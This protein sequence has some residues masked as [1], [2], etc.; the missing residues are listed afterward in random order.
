MIR[1]IFLVLVL[2][3]AHSAIAQN[4]SRTFTSFSKKDNIYEVKVNDGFYRLV[5][6]SS[7]IIETSFIPTGEEFNKESHA[8]IAKPENVNVKVTKAENEIELESENI[9]VKIQKKPFQISYFN[10]EKY[11][12]SEKKGYFKG[13]Y[14]EKHFESTNEYESIEFNLNDD[15]ILYGTGTR[16]LGMDRRGYKLQLYN[17]AHYG[18]TNESVLMNYCMPIVVSSELYMLHFD[19]PAIG[20][21][22][23]D[24]K[25]NNTLAYETI[26]GRK[27]YQLIVGKT[28]EDLIKN[29][30]KLTGTQPM[31]PR[32]A[33]GNFSSRF[34]YRSQ[35]QTVETIDAFQKDE[36]PVDAIILDLYWFG[37]EV[38]G[39]MGNLAF[40]KD[41]FPEPQKMIDELRD[42]NVETILITEPFILTTSDRWDEAVENDVLAK[43]SLGKPY[44][45]DF[46]FGNT[47]IVDIYDE[48][49]FN[50]FKDIYVDLMKMGV[51]GMWGDL[52]EPEVHPHDVIHA[53]GTADE[54]HNIYG[55]DWARLVYEAY[56]N[57]KPEM[58]PFILMR[59]AYSGTQRYGIVPWTGDVSRS[60][61]G[62]QSQPEL[63]LQMGL[64]GIAYMHSDLGGFAFPTLDNELYVRWLQY[65]VFQPIYRPHAQEE[66]PSEPCFREE[67]TKEL[68]KQAIELRYAMLPYNYNLMFENHVSGIPLM[69]PLFFEE[70][71]NK[72][73]LTYI[74][75][76]LWGN[77]FLIAPILEQGQKEV[78]VYFPKTANWFD[79]YT[80]EKYDGGQTVKIKTKEESIP[81]FVR[82][83][84]F[85]PMAKPMQSTKEYDGNDLVLHYYNDV[86]NSFS[87]AEMYN[88]DGK[89]QNAYENGLYEILKFSSIYFKNALKIT[90][91]A[92]IGEKYSATNK[93]IDL[94]VHNLEKTPKKVKVNGKK[95]EFD[96]D[97]Q[98]LKVAVE[99]GT[100]EEIVI[101]IG[102]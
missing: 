50:W 12:T 48:N 85:I 6:Y 72:E 31:M 94:I 82:G 14:E 4:S 17:R 44:T 28:W 66:V 27:T 93:N 2:F 32:W 57:Y 67:H 51:T 84:A 3:F 19:N 76:Y 96:F 79:F 21:L 65:G 53:T 95:V 49:A 30:T 22:D 40:E 47:G 15:E 55:H 101:E 18:Y 68:A 25:E 62:L 34:G 45:Y 56:K 83:G 9:T 91:K 42:K 24:S 46:F 11:I 39:P 8:V 60:W 37:K 16:V 20:Y 74:G 89:T 41:S 71:E 52:G 99:W 23:L 63:A 81:T 61:G 36:I 1:N 70:P 86:S 98:T 73:L 77:D 5:F 97:N 100:A 26:S 90:F 7:E 43:D 88:D 33:L 59:A 58:R 10:D 35:K 29:Y 92:E 13:E 78:E 69:R 64:Q 87:K 54:V 75:T 102:F 38:H 80:G